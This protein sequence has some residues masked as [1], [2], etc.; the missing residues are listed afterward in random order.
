MTPGVLGGKPRI[1]G[2]RVRVHDIVVHHLVFGEPIAEIVG[3]VFPGLTAADVHAALAFY[4]DNQDLVREIMA[5]EESAERWYRA[6][7]SQRVTPS[8]GG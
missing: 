3:E 8:R 4:F 1:A 6:Q 7:Q 2:T 5:E